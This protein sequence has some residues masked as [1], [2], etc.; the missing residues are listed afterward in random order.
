MAREKTF[1]GWYVHRDG[2]P[3]GPL[4]NDEIARMIAEGQ[5]QAAEEILMGCRDGYGQI[6]FFGSH[7]HTAVRNGRE[8]KPAARATPLRV[9]IVDDCHDGANT[10][11]S[12]LRLWGYEAQVAHNGATALRLADAFHPQV[13]LLDIGLPEMDGYHLARHLREQPNFQD[14]L[15]VAISGYGGPS[16]RAQGM[17]AGFDVYLVKPVDPTAMEELLD[18]WGTGKRLA[19]GLPC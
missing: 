1:L 17:E 14:S 13:F 15:M 11:A 8:R 10:L 2:Q 9:L 19:E 5:L 7:A 16:Y 6:W 4:S 3:V 12:L 18:Q